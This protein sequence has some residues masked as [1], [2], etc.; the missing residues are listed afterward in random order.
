MAL[1]T[2]QDKLRFA[3]RLDDVLDE[4]EQ[5]KVEAPHRVTLAL[6]GAAKALAEAQHEMDRIVG[7]AARMLNR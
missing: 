5:L 7:Q 4:V 3:K 6:A 2:Y 1:L